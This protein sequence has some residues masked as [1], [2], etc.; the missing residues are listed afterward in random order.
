[1]PGPL[2]N[3]GFGAAILLCLAALV[4]GSAPLDLARGQ[5]NAASEADAFEA[6]KSW[7]SLG[8][9]VWFDPD[10]KRVVLRA[11]VALRDGALE[12]F[13]CLRNT[14]EHEA[15]VATEAP[16][17]MIHAALLLTGV[18]PGHPV[19]YRPQFQPPEGPRIAI[20]VE[21]L[22]NGKTQ[23]AAAKDWV[24]DL[25]SDKPLTKDWVFAGSELL[26]DAASKQTI[27]AAD[28]GDLITVANFPSS[29]LDLP[30]ASSPD[31]ADRT[32]VA[33]TPLI[34]P[35]GT[36][37]TIYLRPAEKSRGVTPKTP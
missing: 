23:H 21:W 36:R 12:H 6:P 34:P 5:E 7:K 37:V 11:R 31:D 29:I 14:K 32:F 3:R 30:F 28:D 26:T 9:D 27:Y 15:I 33:N 18:E 24:K 13:L 25:K 17:R 8:K 35:K 20:D 10:G 16:P 19:R 2:N 22:E 4:T 1:M